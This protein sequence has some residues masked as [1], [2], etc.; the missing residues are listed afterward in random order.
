M[1]TGNLCWAMI[2]VWAG[3]YAMVIA[4]LG[5]LAMSVRAFLRWAPSGQDA[6]E[7]DAD[8]RAAQ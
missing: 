1:M 8:A 4:N 6:P 3:S 7:A 2:G 5:F